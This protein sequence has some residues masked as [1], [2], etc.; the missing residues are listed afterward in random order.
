MG[1]AALAR[2]PKPDTE[3]PPRPTLTPSSA[4]FA[5]PILS[6]A[7]SS[8]PFTNT[9]P[10][11]LSVPLST[12]PEAKLQ[13]Q[14]YFP[15]PRV[16]RSARV[17]PTPLFSAAFADSEPSPGPILP[18]FYEFL[19]ELDPDLQPLSHWMPQADQVEVLEVEEPEVAEVAAPA[20]TKA[21]TKRP[22]PLYLPPM[23][24]VIPRLRRNDTIQEE[25]E[26]ELELDASGI[27]SGSS[28]PT[29]TL[30]FSPHPS[31][32]MS[33]CDGATG[34][35]S[36][37]GPGPALLPSPYWSPTADAI[38]WSCPELPRIKGLK[39]LRLPAMVSLAMQA[40]AGKSL[41]AEDDFPVLAARVPAA[42]P[43]STGV[44]EGPRKGR[45]AIV[46][47]R[48][49]SLPPTLPMFELDEDVQGRVE[50][51]AGERPAGTPQRRASSYDQFWDA[52]EELEVASV[53]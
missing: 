52:L 41:A 21:G 53:C 25:S 42:R 46:I 26:T 33:E 39:P 2:P 28:S 24:V 43:V 19:A 29:H 10:A 6:L 17:R 40:G 34:S 12:P 14:V 22:A 9:F 1:G 31:P 27:S 5:V 23:P 44:G 45:K 51:K 48:A 18:N 13:S 7:S 49:A 16:A 50:G 8:T 32:S 11:P 3:T 38:E 37:P 30:L 47:G 4:A 15:S 36:G 35:G 20:R